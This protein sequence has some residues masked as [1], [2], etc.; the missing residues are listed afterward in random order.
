MSVSNPPTCTNILNINGISCT[1]DT[2]ASKVT[3]SGWS[4]AVAKSTSVQ[5]K[6]GTVTNPSAQGTDPIQ[7]RTYTTSA[8]T[9]IID[10]DL[11][12]MVPTLACNQPCR[13]CDANDKSSCTSCY[14]T[15]S[16]STCRAAAAWPRARPAG[17]TRARSPALS[18][19]PFAQPATTTTRRA[20]SCATR[21]APRPSST[22]TAASPSA[23]PPCTA[24]PL[25]A[26]IAFRPAQA[27]ALRLS[28][29]PASTTAQTLLYTCRA[30]SASRRVP[31]AALPF[32][33]P[34]PHARTRVSSARLRRA[35]ALSALGRRSCT[36]ANATTLAQQ[37]R[38]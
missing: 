16:S 18:A 3:A 29:P 17:S 7:L 26:P 25:S 34:A 27:A 4:V 9:Y 36:R 11:T 21:Q 38:T 20:V 10:Q 35:R 37:V 30:I 14:E 13:T 32:P 6:L 23:P 28:A 8:A 12:T 1:V 2:V 15:G 31:T 19:T 5:F 33:L 22:T 24:T